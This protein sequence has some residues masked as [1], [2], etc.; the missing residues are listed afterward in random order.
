[1]EKVFQ[2]DIAS[3]TFYVVD[4]KYAKDIMENSTIQESTCAVIASI[5]KG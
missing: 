3:V 2:K 4:N 5:R 1:M